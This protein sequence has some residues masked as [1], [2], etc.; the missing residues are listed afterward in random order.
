[1][2]AMGCNY[3]GPN[4]LAPKQTE[5]KPVAQCNQTKP[6]HSIMSAVSTKPNQPKVKTEPLKPVPTQNVVRLRLLL[7]LLYSRLTVVGR[8]IVGQQAEMRPR[9]LGVRAHDCA[10][11]GSIGEEKCSAWAAVLGWLKGW[12]LGRGRGGNQP[13]C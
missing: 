3:L 7:G 10:R 2:C 9:G 1:M 5:P 6:D 8:G 11:S 12:L 13:R 4:Y